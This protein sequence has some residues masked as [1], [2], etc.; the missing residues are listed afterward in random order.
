MGHWAKEC[1]NRKQEKKA[2]S[3]LAQADEDD[4]STLLMAMFCA[5]LDVEAKEME[6]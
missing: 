4:E 2:E 3:H 1:P 5:L 6:R